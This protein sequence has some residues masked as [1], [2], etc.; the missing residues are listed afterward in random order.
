VYWLIVFP[1]AYVLAFYFEFEVPGLW[2]SMTIGL[3]LLSFAFLWIIYSSDWDDLSRKIVDRIQKE[4]KEPTKKNLI[5]Q[6]E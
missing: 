5:N 2:M 3:I 1:L 4:Q 6:D